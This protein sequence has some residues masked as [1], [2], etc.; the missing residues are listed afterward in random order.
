MKCGVDEG[1]VELKLIHHQ[2]HSFMTRHDHFNRVLKND[3]FIII[4]AAIFVPL[5]KDHNR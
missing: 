2:I 3:H 1:R 5:R 4:N